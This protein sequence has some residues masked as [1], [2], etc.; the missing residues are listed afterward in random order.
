MPKKSTSNKLKAAPSKKAKSLSINGAIGGYEAINH[1]NSRRRSPPRWTAA[2]EWHLNSTQRIAMSANARDLARNM[3]LVVSAMKKH[4]SFI[5]DLNFH[6]CTA[7]RGFNRALEQWWIEECRPERFDAASRHSWQRS[8]RLTEACRLLDGD[9]G[10]LKIGN[11]ARRGC[12]QVIEGD[13]IGT[14]TMML[15][16]D[17]DPQFWSNGV[18]IDTATGRAL[19]YAICNRMGGTG[20]VLDRVVPARNLMLH[21]HYGFRFDQVRGVSVIAAAMNQFRDCAETIDYAY[22]KVKLSQ[23]MGWIVTR[24]DDGTGPVFGAGTVDYQ[25]DTDA[26]GENDAAPVIDP[27]MS[28]PFVT[29]LN[30]GEDIKLLESGTPSTETMAFIRFTVQLALSTLGIP[31]CMWDENFGSYAGQKAAISQYLYTCRDHI[32]DLRWLAMQHARWAMGLAIIDNELILPS[33][34]DFD[35]VDNSFEFVSGEF[36]W[37]DQVKDARSTAMEIAMGLTNPYR[38]A[39]ERGTRAEDNADKTQQFIEYCES[40]GLPV[41][42]TDST[43]FAPNV[44]S[45]GNANDSTKPY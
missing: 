16:D 8:L 10:W 43:L 28:A 35:F 1:D 5:T 21:A 30:K 26:D 33:G 22:A 27:K 38:A 23:I 39:Q 3:P 29:E 14:P 18:Q 17:F 6:A 12:V 40:I 4:V 37:S 41:T 42:Y 31:Y 9:V 2:E 13:R 32:A 45:D 11:G 24:D 34:K 19:N 36:P 7:D 20:K 44:V 15:P 25:Q